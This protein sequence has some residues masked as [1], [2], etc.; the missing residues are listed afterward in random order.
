MRRRRRRGVVNAEQL[1]LITGEQRSGTTLL[2]RMLDAQREVRVVADYLHIDRLLDSFDG[3]TLES[4]LD[5]D[6]KR[7]LLQIFS[8]DTAM[9]DF[10]VGM[11]SDE[12]S[13][14]LDFYYLALD[15][16][17]STE[18]VVGHKTTRAYAIIPELARSD[19][20]LHVIFMM[21]DPRAVIPSITRWRDRH[22]PEAMSE[23]WREGFE[24][25]QR[26]SKDK[27]LRGRF[28]M[29]KYEDL[30]LKPED[31]ADQLSG[32]LGLSSFQTNVNFHDNLGAAWRGNSSFGE[33][34]DRID[35]TPVERWRDED[36]DVIAYI[37]K[38][39]SSE[40]N[41]IGYERMFD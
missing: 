10:V 37:E 6:Q 39:L 13:S 32:F 19:H 5:R 11:R 27:K 23:S 15:R 40:M 33:L 29:L 18:R 21:R 14:L 41:S 9:L 31:A 22:T 25:F 26:Y 2:A 4:P 3:C 1:V 30:V 38:E 34:S 24:A 16:V 12:F 36:P 35:Q 20:R 17:S 8:R 28:L 7:R